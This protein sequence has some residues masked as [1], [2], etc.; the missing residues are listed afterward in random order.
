MFLFLLTFLTSI[1]TAPQFVQ[2]FD[3]QREVFVFLRE[4]AVE[5]PSTETPKVYSRV[6]KVCKV[7]LSPACN[8]VHIC[9]SFLI[10]TYK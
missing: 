5:T 3:G 9:Q 7:M 4:T 8:C 10:L 6:A 1:S 2:S